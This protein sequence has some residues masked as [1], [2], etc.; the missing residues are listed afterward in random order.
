MFPKGRILQP[1][2]FL[3]SSDSSFAGAF[4]FIDRHFNIDSSNFK[5]EFQIELFNKLID[6]GED[7]WTRRFHYFPEDS[8]RRVDYEIYDIERTS[9]GGYILGGY[10]LSYDSI[11]VGKTWT[12]W[13]C[14]KN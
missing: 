11:D 1:K 4:S 3:P 12:V 5:T 9:D 6:S 14:N 2:E 8:M 7:I 13:I 10:T